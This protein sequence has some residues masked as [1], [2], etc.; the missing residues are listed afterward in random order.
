M[1]T[2]RMAQRCRAQLD[3]LDRLQGIAGLEV[4]KGNAG[5][6]D[7]HRD[8]KIR[9]LHQFRQHLLQLARRPRRAIDHVRRHAL[10]AIFVHWRG[11]LPAGA[12]LPPERPLADALEVS[13]TT[14]VLAY[15]DIL[16]ALP[17]TIRRRALPHAGLANE[18]RGYT[19]RQGSGT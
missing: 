11:S 1:R 9:G 7:V 13:R 17:E 14:V 5:V 15:G 4:V 6:H 3:P 19:Q 10:E 8:W 2:A 16:A 18:S 12:R